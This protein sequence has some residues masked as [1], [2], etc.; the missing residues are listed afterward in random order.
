MKI[1]YFL[2]PLVFLMSCG[3]SEDDTTITEDDSTEVTPQNDAEFNARAKREVTGKLG[4]PANEKYTVQVYR[5][6]INSDT[7][8]DAIV[9]V[10]RLE[11][12][13]D[14]AIKSGKQAKKAETGFMGNYNF[15]F[16]YDGAKDQFS[17]PLPVPSSPGRPLDVSFQHILSETSN[18]VVIGYRVLNSGYQSYFSVFNESDLALV[19]QWKQ[20]DKI[21]DPQPEAYIQKAVSTPDSHYKDIC[22]YQ[23][24]I[25][26]YNT[27]IS[28]IYAYVPQITKQ[29][30]LLYQFTFDPRFGKFKL[31]GGSEFA[32]ASSKSPGMPPRPLKQ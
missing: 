25:D 9:T 5:E 12:A 6:Y 3:E 17:V 16:Y 11:F 27:N 22:I 28:D 19:F 30:T 29:G 23:S 10:N 20:F 26:G 13:M 15:F 4:I 32:K 14:E 24:E 2:L 21:G 7:I 8:I 1:V 18:D 31:I